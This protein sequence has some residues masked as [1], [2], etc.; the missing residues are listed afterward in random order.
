MNARERPGAL[1]PQRVHGSGVH[2][3]LHVVPAQDDDEA[4][5]ESLFFLLAL[6]AGAVCG[7]LVAIG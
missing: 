7:Y 5:D 3:R 4:F 1:L 2:V 6:L